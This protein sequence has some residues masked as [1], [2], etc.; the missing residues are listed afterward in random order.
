MNVSSFIDVYSLSLKALMETCDDSVGCYYNDF[1]ES[2]CLNDPICP[3]ALNDGF[4]L[5]K[6]LDGQTKGYVCEDKCC[7]KV[8]CGDGTVM[9]GFETCEDGNKRNKDGCD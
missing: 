2:C 8:E 1:D 7:V 6:S 9:E 4:V 3:G 5:K